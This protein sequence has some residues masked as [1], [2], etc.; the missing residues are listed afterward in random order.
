MLLLK[1]I[2]WFN[3]LELV[4]DKNI[5]FNNWIDILNVRYVIK[6]HLVNHDFILIYFFIF[7]FIYC[8]L[9]DILI[10][11]FQNLLKKIL[12]KIEKWIESI[13]RYLIKTLTMYFFFWSKLSQIFTYV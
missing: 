5:K 3:Y 11:V 10:I 2:S 1:M 8:Y 7:I 9:Y 4:M 13:D 12:K 6:Y